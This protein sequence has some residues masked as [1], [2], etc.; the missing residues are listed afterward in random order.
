VLDADSA[1]GFRAELRQ[2]IAAEI[3]RLFPSLQD[4]DKPAPADDWQAPAAG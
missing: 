2:A 3:R 4:S 1:A